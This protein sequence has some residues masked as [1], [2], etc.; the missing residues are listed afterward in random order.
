M[1]NMKKDGKGSYRR[2]IFP[3]AVLLLAVIFIV[4]QHK[5]QETEYSIIQAIIEELPDYQDDIE[6]WGYRVS[7]LQNHVFV[8]FYGS[9]RT[10][11]NEQGIG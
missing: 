11:E 9:I 1:G 4:W 8:E 2:W 3:I 7:V 6:S 5:R 10:A